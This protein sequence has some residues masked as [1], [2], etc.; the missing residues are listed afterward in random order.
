MKPSQILAQALQEVEEAGIQDD[1]RPVAFAK[2]VDLLCG[3]LRS[4][5]PQGR[6]ESRSQSETA[7]PLTANGSAIVRIAERLKLDMGVVSQVYDCEGDS[8]RVIV[9]S[10]RLG[11]TVAQATR[12]L[13]LLVA[14]GRQAGGYDPEW[15]SVAEIRAVCEEYGKYD[16]ANFASIIKGMDNCFLMKDKGIQR[17]V[18]LSRPGWEA[19]ADLV[20]KMAGVEQA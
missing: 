1:L 20:A 18:K 11:S 3:A 10:G 2:A 4:N 12:E 8:L 9:P 13:A 19:A 14:A 17:K 7:G 16:S 6:P 15:T 5:V